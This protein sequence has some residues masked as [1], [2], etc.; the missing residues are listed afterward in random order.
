MPEPSRVSFSRQE[1]ADQSWELASAAPD[2]RLSDYVLDYQGYRERALRPVRRLQAPFAGIP[3]I[4]SFGPRLDI[5]N[6]DAPAAGASHGSFLAGLHDVHVFTEFVGTQYG[7]QVNFSLLGAFR[8]LRLPMQEIAN[9]CVDLEDLLGGEAAELRGRLEE[10]P[11][12]E[13][14]CA[15]MDAFLLRRIGAG[16]AMSPDVAW[17]LRMLQQSR[18]ARSIGALTRKLGCSRRHLI[19]RFHAQAG[20]SPKAIAGIF[21]FEAATA[22]IRAGEER[23]A[24]LALA[25][26]YSDQAHF[27]RDFRRY[28]GRT[29]TEYRAA[30]RSDGLGVAG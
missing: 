6:G 25:C 19:R 21:R 30:A 20:L 27:S 4:V 10:A 2:S 28:A 24:E 1:G 5:L 16:R 13:R 17:S 7:F 26:G 9:R 11:D 29:P 3:M 14:R 12:W 8:F 23:W 18:G 22:R 15:V